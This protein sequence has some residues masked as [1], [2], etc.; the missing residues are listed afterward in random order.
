MKLLFLLITLTIFSHCS[1]HETESPRKGLRKLASRPES[2][3]IG[4]SE[5]DTLITKRGTKLIV[6]KGALVLQNGEE[7]SDLVDMEV[8]EIFERSEMIFNR[9]TTTCKDEMIESFGMVNIKATSNGD[10]VRVK[11][12]HALTIIL[13]A[14]NDAGEAEIFYGVEEGDLID[15]VLEPTINRREEIKGLG[16]GQE[17]VRVTH[18]RISV[19]GTEI[20][21]PVADSI[22]TRASAFT[23]EDM[24]SYDTAADYLNS[25]INIGMPILK[26]SELGWINC[27]RFLVFPKDLLGAL[28][29]RL[30][31]YKSPEGYM[32]F[33]NFN[34]IIPIAFDREGFGMIKGLPKGQ[35]VQIIVID[36]IGSDYRFAKHEFVIGS[37]TELKLQ[38][39]VSS[40]QKIEEELRELDK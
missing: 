21:L 35:P 26:A 11:D 28:M 6:P 5:S 37:K 4:N 14:K 29:I 36:K 33:D 34:T 2:F 18:S 9:A 12:G 40:I 16:N 3:K 1:T 22:Y 27:D 13:P 30:E 19:T 39:D 23:D 38:T 31:M 17:E 32:V 8:L 7:I 25:N 10:E 24:I 15:W 20:Q